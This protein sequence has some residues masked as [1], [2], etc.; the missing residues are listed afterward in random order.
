MNIPM[1][2]KDL[3]SRARWLPLMAA[4]SLLS[5]CAIP[6]QQGSAASQPPSASGKQ[7]QVPSFFSRLTHTKEEATLRTLITQQDQLY[8]VAAPLL[9]SNTALCRGYER[10]LLGFTAKNIYSYPPD[11]TDAAAALGL[12]E[13][14]SITGVLP[15][16]GASTKGIQPKDILVAAGNKQMP[17][18]PD[19][20]RQ[21]AIVLSPLVMGN[22]PVKLTLERD[23]RR[24]TT[25]VPLTLACAFSIELG[26]SDNVNSYADGRRVLVTRG[27][28]EFTRSDEELAYVIAREIA[29]NALG[30][31]TRQRMVAT[32][33]GVIDNLMRMQPDMS[34]M[35]GTAGIRPYPQ[36]M[37]TAADT[38]ALYMLARAGYNIDN[39]PRFW[40]RLA[41]QY[42]A[43][44]PNAYTALHPSVQARLH[45]IQRAAE[46][47]RLKQEH[48][49]DLIP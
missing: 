1:T 24:I 11:Y 12:T 44:V 34:A 45:A 48:Q 5:A 20:E 17:S 32:I 42:P 46:Q 3:F 15:D 21:A 39:A 25:T 31:A 41:D 13:Y 22:R 23:G 7:G 16:S 28:L 8:R 4:V 14:L 26:N 10:N 40:R 37:D 33:G 43:R 19:A 27:M 36:H 2:I 6:E 18:G 9:T 47:I 30:H 29:H 49:Q 35:A 38:L